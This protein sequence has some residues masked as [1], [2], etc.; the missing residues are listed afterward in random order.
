MS[1]LMMKLL[2]R[3]P[4]HYFQSDLADWIPIVGGCDAVGGEDCNC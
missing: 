1:A 4:I 3:L 2:H